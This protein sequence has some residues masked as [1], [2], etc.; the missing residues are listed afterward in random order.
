[1]IDEDDAD[2]DD[3]EDVFSASV[4]FAS[5]LFLVAFLPNIFPGGVF[6]LLVVLMV[7]D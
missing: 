1:M 2:D 6:S 7:C 5:Y 3:D 4:F